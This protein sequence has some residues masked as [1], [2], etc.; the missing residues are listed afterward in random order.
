M[1]L[2]SEWQFLKQHKMILVVMYD[3]DRTY[4]R[5]CWAIGERGSKA[6]VISTNTAT[7][8]A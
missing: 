7:P 5:P 6:A 2:K 8:A 4:R 3:A 1:M